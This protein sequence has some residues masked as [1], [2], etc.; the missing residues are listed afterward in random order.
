MSGWCVALLVVMITAT[1][2]IL[3]WAIL[4]ACGHSLKEMA[5]GHPPVEPAPGAVRRDFQS[6][7]I[8]IFNLGWSIH[9]AVDADYLHLYPARI[10]R[11]MGMVPMSIPWE[12][13]EFRKKGWGK[14]GL[15]GAT[16][17]IGKQWVTGPR[18]ALQL[19]AERV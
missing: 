6:F 4:R 8:G 12:E 3:V 10:A 7:K 16:V 11:W 17:R 1:D 14:S 19:A 13:V 2:G 9:V 18:W 5:H 15:G